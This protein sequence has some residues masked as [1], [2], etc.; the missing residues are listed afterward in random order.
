MNKPLEGESSLYITSIKN[1]RFKLK[2]LL[3]LYRRQ[4]G[5]T[6]TKGLKPT[7]TKKQY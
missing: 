7:S 4:I 3:D 5:M 2:G 1:T 6:T